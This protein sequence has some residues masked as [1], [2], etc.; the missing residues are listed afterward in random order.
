MGF[1]VIPCGLSLGALGVGMGGQ[2]LK[3]N[4]SNAANY[5]LLTLLDLDLIPSYLE[6]EKPNLDHPVCSE[7]DGLSQEDGAIY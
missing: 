2:W 7:I 4:P 5:N 1:R 6:S 3:S